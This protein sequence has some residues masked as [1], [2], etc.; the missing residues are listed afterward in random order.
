MFL[1]VRNLGEGS[2]GPETY[3]SY[4]LLGETD[5]HGFGG[6]GVKLA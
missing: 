3:D 6:L 1:V 2:L 4:R 5:S